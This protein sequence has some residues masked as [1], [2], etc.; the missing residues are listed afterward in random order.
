MITQ[1]VVMVPA[2]DNSFKYQNGL[3]GGKTTFVKKVGIYDPK[4]KGK[5]GK[6]CVAMTV[7]AHD[8]NHKGKGAR[9]RNV[10]MGHKQW[11]DNQTQALLRC[12]IANFGFGVNWENY[13]INHTVKQA[14]TKLQSLV[15]KQYKKM[16]GGDGKKTNG[17]NTKQ[18][19]QS[20]LARQ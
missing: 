1:A 4:H 17:T 14:Q 10:V 5:G 11:D 9:A 18:L 15:R 16:N 20:L 2:A 6:A 7:G 19:Y 12:V 3:K 13:G 8:P